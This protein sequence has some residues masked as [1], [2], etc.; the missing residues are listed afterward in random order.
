MRSR[1]V[2][3]EP[4]NGG[5][6]CE[7]AGSAA[8]YVTEKC[9]LEPC[10]KDKE[11]KPV[12]CQW[13]AWGSWSKC[14]QCGGVMYRSRQVK[15]HAEY[16]GKN[17]ST[18]TSE[19]MAACDHSCFDNVHCM[20]QSWESWSPCSL[21]C[22]PAGHHG[23]GGGKRSRTRTLKAVVVNTANSSKLWETESTEDIEGQ[24]QELYRRAQAT[25]SKRWQEISAAFALGCFTFVIG[26]SFVAL[27]QRRVDY[28]HRCSTAAL[29][30]QQV[31]PP[32]S[33][34]LIPSSGLEMEGVFADVE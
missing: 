20:W 24:V 22:L 31:V 11:I 28:F 30:E 1:K 2:I 12:D 18:N 9:K 29:V 13:A 8:L 5:K 6:A 19:E 15:A 14:K 27:W 23:N 17:C 25:E 10:E 7:T 3:V 34:R 32:C 4:Q 33:A 26:F 21:S 16:G